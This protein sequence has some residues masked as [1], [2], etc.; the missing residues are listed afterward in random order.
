MTIQHGKLPT[1]A[2]LQVIL[3]RHTV[4]FDYGMQNQSRKYKVIYPIA[5]L[6]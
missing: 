3:K 2:D 4:G 5:M 1:W 6:R